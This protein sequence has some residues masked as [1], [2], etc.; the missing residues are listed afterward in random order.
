MEIR[1]PMEIRTL[2]PSDAPAFWQLRLEALEQE[3][4]AFAEAPEE[5]RA[6]PVAIVASRLFDF[7]DDTFVLGAFFD[8]QLQGTLGFARNRQ[9]KL[10][11]K[12]TVWGVYVSPLCRG[13]GAGRALMKALLER[14]GTIEGLRQIQL[15]VGARNQAARGLYESCGF[16]VFGAERE[17][18]CINEEWFDELHMVLR[19]TR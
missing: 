17:S 5:H 12:G 15:K 8:G 19:L 1:G 18:L 13:R 2:G 9:I 11:H 4:S 3:P 14:A 16:E 6:T 10:R 7:S